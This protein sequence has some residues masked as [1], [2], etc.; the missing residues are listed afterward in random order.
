M[1]LIGILVKNDPQ[2][3]SSDIVK[4]FIVPVSEYRAILTKRIRNLR[5]E[6]QISVN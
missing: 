3:Q 5:P 2:S 6:N 1:D 4:R